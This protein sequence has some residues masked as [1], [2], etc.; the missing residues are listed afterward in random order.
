MGQEQSKY[1]LSKDDKIF[2]VNE[3][4]SFTELGHLDN[5]LKSKSIFDYSQNPKGT[6]NKKTSKWLYVSL[7]LFIGF[8][9]TT[10]IA[11]N[12]YNRPDQYPLDLTVPANP[13]DDNELQIKIDSLQTIIANHSSQQNYSYS[14][15]EDIARLQAE[16]QTLKKQVEGLMS[17]KQRLGNE[18]QNQSNERSDL[19]S[20]N[21]KLKNQVDRLISKNQNLG[22][23]LQKLKE[24]KSDLISENKKLKKQVEGLVNQLMH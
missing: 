13:I 21:R 1:H 14:N 9:A 2:R 6:S 20:E 3:D 19:I 4:G 10:I 5:L 17:K 8:C 16:N 7:I 18:P 23:E 11:I 22:N 15:K 24:E 12:L